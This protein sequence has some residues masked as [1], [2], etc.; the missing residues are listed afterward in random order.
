MCIILVQ[1]K[2][3]IPDNILKECWKGNSDGAGFSFVRKNILYYYKGLMD[4]D[5]FL[6]AY[7]KSKILGEAVIHFR[8]SSVGKIS[9][10]NTHP[11]EIPTKNMLLYHNGTLSALGNETMSDSKMLSKILGK[12]NHEEIDALLD[13]FYG[14]FVIHSLKGIKTYGSFVRKETKHYAF[15]ASN[16]GFEPQKVHYFHS[17]KSPYLNAYEE[18]FNFSKSDIKL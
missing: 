12:L 18:V 3:P 4:Y 14:K 11:H 2:G 16:N 13:Q 15:S 7:K 5:S 6:K 10:G 8:I 9:K 1:N 17:R